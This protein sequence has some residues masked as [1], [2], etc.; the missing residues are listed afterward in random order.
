MLPVLVHTCRQSPLTS[1]PAGWTSVS[2]GDIDIYL[3]R[4][5]Y[6]MFE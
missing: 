3:A 1:S 5:A 4:E 6:V 2:V